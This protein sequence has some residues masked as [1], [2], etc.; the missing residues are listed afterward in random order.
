MKV[1][2]PPSAGIGA[3]I[4]DLDVRALTADR[5]AAIRDLV[6]RHKLV[7]F[8][9]LDLNDDDYLTMARRFGRPQVY[10][11]DHYH[12]PDH[13]EI[14]VSSNVEMGGKKV[15]VAGTGRFWHSDYQFFDEPLSWTFVY[16]KVIPRGDRATLYVDMVAAWRELPAHLRRELEHARCF[17]EAVM[18]YKVQPRDVDRAIAEL[19]QEFRQLSPGA[20]H[21]AVITHPVSGEQA[22]YVSEGFTMKVE[23]RS[24]EDSQR[25][26][27]EVFAFLREPQRVHAHP[28]G[29]GDL[30]LWEN[31]TL[32]HR[33][34]GIPPGEKSVSYRIGVYDGQ[35]FYRGCKLEETRLQEAAS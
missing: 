17:H 34:S 10:F 19:M 31:R 13:P 23:G 22:L 5:V 33:S 12:H 8:R 27:Q 4:R 21:P 9:G 24:H 7:V 32:I 26:L 15:G 2:P 28:W 3:E 35:P 25:I 11:Q 14:F 16:P 30:M 18:Y 1:I 29:A 20:G 6:V